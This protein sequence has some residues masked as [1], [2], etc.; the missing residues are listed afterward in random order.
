MAENEKIIPEAEETA[1]KVEAAPAEEAKAEEADAPV[2]EVKKEKKEKAPKEKKPVNV[3]LIGIIAG[4]AVAVI[5]VALLVI[6]LIFGGSAT[7][8][9]KDG[10]YAG[11]YSSSKLAFFMNSTDKALIESKYIT[12]V[13]CKEGK[14]YEAYELLEASSMS[15]EEKDKIYAANNEVAMCKPGQVVTLGTY[16]GDEV[17]WLVLDVQVVKAGGKKIAKAFLMSRDIIGAPAGWG[18]TTNYK[19]SELHSF[20][21]VTFANS[22]AM[23][24]SNPNM[25]LKSKITTADGDVTCRAF[26][27]S[28]AEI[29]KYLV[30]DFAEYVAADV[31][32]GAKKAG[33][34]AAGYDAAYYVREIGK[35]DGE[36][37]YASGYN[38]DGEFKDGFTMAGYGVG[39]RICINVNLGEI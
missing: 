16:D 27:P 6:A 3:K 29:E 34:S 32:K 4:A 38:K 11:A 33:V 5:V 7:G 26:A 24:L 31:T 37:Q 10:D 23:S 30:G 2:E 20:C 28:K 17:A 14:Y 39:A 1:E 13:L 18:G 35:K 22:F 12:E 15:K 25:I 36:T 21:D 19:D 8:A 9:Y